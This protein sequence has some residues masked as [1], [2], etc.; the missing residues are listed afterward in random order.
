M[1]PQLYIAMFDKN[2]GALQSMDTQKTI[3]KVCEDRDDKPCTL[4]VVLFCSYSLPV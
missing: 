2:P 4:H 3:Q 1:L